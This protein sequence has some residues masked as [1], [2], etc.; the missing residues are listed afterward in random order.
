MDRVLE[1]QDNFS[2]FMPAD[3]TIKKSEDTDDLTEMRIAGFASTSHPD[4]QDDIIL[5]KG[6][7]I[8]DFLNYGFLNYDHDNS[9]IVGYPD[10]EKTGLRPSGFWVE[11][12]LL[13]GIPLAKS[14]WDTAV[15]LKK[16]GADRKMGFS[17]EGKTLDRD[18]QGRIT[19][20]KVYNVAVT[21]N[22]VNTTCTWDALVKSFSTDLD[23]VT[24]TEVTKAMEAGYSTNI[25]E[26]NNGASLKTESLESAF[27]ILAKAGCG[28]AESCEVLKNIMIDP[29]NNTDEAILYFQ[30][31]RGLSRSEATKLV[32]SLNLM[33]EE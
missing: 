16:S 9:K 8:S 5:Q 4:R 1:N 24:S 27:R 10:K 26:V 14:I 15:S 18:A 17:I 30:I 31:S 2:F 29:I 33:K 22:P 11:G 7:D 3:V 12:I 19:R 28:H 32:E 13:P 23:S 20:A 25:G 21:S 6:L